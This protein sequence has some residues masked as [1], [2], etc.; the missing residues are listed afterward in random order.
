M[1]ILIGLELAWQSLCASEKK[2]TEA[3]IETIFE[4]ICSFL[5]GTPFSVFF[6]E[7]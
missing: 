5:P 2:S 7:A 4:N 3:A 6:Q 1:A